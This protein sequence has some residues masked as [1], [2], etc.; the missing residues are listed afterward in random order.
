MFWFLFVLAAAAFVPC[1]L[2]PEWRDYQAAR[3]AEEVATRETA[4]LRTELD[5]QRRALEAVRSDPAVVERMARRELAYGKPGELV[6]AVAATSAEDSPAL[7]DPVAAPS[8]PAAVERIL[9]WIP[10]AADDNLFCDPPTRRLIMGLCGALLVS[11]F[12]LFPPRR[13]PA[14]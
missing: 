8:P 13:A 10:F 2:L 11:A 5:Q 9:S 1:V 4:R 7:P 6:M 12:I 14:E 3:V